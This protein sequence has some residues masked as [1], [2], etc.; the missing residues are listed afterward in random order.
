L[1]L[2]IARCLRPTRQTTEKTESF[3]LA[4]DMFDNWNLP[5]P[6]RHSSPTVFIK[7]LA[8]ARDRRITHEHYS[9]GRYGT[10]QVPQGY[11]Q[12]PRAAGASFE[13]TAQRL[14]EAHSS[15]RIGMLVSRPS[16][17]PHM[18]KSR[19]TR[20]GIMQVMPNPHSRMAM[21]EKH[22]MVSPAYGYRQAPTPHIGFSPDHNLRNCANSMEAPR[23]LKDGSFRG[24]FGGQTVGHGHYYTTLAEK[25]HP[26]D[27][28]HY[29]TV[30]SRPV[31]RK[32]EDI[33]L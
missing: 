23:Y 12:A 5:V 19:A 26:A 10:S 15:L 24:S 25:M 6:E 3:A 27:L 18:A 22:G 32:P 7:H 33:F 16:N 20:T 31:G 29:P 4:E 2:D 9:V 28:R 11:R 1:T 8:D 13:P 17:I 14:H 21:L 30:A